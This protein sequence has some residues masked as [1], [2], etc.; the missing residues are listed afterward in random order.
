MTGSDNAVEAALWMLAQLEPQTQ[1]RVRRLLALKLEPP[2]QTVTESRTLELRAVAD[3][4]RNVPSPRR[5]HPRV[6]RIDYDTQRP[7]GAPSSASL[8]SRYGSWI[9]VCHHSHRLAEGL[10]THAVKRRGQPMPRYTRDH[11]VFA[12]REC[13]RELNRTPSRAA[14]RT[15]RAAVKRRRKKRDYYPSAPWFAQRYAAQGGWVAALEDAGLI[16]PPANSLRIVVERPEQARSLA[17][18][19]RAGGLVAARQQRRS[20]EVRADVHELRAAL[21]ALEEPLNALT[22]WNPRTRSAE[23]AR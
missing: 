18:L 17:E 9:A 3:L 16:E 7:I 15:W 12:L 8:V 1:R 2:A 14:Y 5:G 13:A 21:R 22:I 4:I 23:P 10:P 20:V 19:L 11:F 6:R